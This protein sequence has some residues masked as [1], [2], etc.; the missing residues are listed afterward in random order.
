MNHKYGTT[1][2]TNR[3]YHTQLI[4]VSLDKYKKHKERLLDYEETVE[5]DFFEY[6]DVKKTTLPE[7]FIVG[8]YLHI[9]L[10]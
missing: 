3:P 6:I 4:W 10:S 9:R 1:L 7:E 8:N 5:E 2:R